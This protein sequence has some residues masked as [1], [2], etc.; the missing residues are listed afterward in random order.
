VLLPTLGAALALLAGSKP[1]DAS[2]ENWHQLPTRILDNPLSLWIG[3]TSYAMYLA[4][5]PIVALY[6]Y[7]MGLEPTAL[8]QALL[9]PAIVA[10]TCLL[11]YGVERRFYQ[12]DT[13]ASNA[14]TGSVNVAHRHALQS[15]AKCPWH[16]GPV[17]TILASLLLVAAL[18][19]SAWLGDGWA[20]REPDVVLTADAIKN[21]MQRRYTHIRNACPIEQLATHESCDTSKP[22][23]VL[24]FG[25]SHEPDG[26][27]FLHAGYSGEAVNLIRFGTT[28]AC[29]GLAPKG[30]AVSDDC[31][32][33]LATLLSPE[34][35]ASLDVILYVANK[36]FRDN[37]APYVEILRQLK[38]YNPALRVITMGGYINTRTDCWR[39]INA[40]RSTSACRN[41]ANV[42]YFADAPE[43]QPMYRDIMALTDHFVDRVALLCRNRQLETCAI[44]AEN[45]TPAFYDP[46]HLSLEF[47]SMAGRQYAMQYPDLLGVER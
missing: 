20:W 4:H 34:V 16:R 29:P 6:R 13:A 26:F 11:H 27:N 40:A 46:H 14:L 25:N 5:W 42:S 23:Q 12:R 41:P 10:A 21:G 33:R 36:P 45:G 19:L 32:E 39:L 18:P 37:K 28:N 17:A 9:A 15:D 43:A 1:A 7:E 35:A 38:Q 2:T 24:V 44:T 22:L 47:A 31:R 8:A 30:V 3:R